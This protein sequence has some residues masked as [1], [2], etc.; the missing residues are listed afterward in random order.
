MKH[1]VHE[2]RQGDETF[3][4]YYSFYSVNLSFPMSSLALIIVSYYC[5]QPSPLTCIHL[6][7]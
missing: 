1:A 7:L 3:L 5:L 6:M 2:V 4:F